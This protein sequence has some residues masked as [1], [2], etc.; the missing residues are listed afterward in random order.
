MLTWGQAIVLALLQGVSELFP[1][2][3]LGHTVLLPAILGWGD[4]QRDPTFVPFVVVLHLGTAAALLWF[5][6][7]EWV[8]VVRAFVRSAYRGRLAQTPEEHLA[9]MLFFGTIPAGVLGALFEQP[10]KAL[11]ATPSVAAVFLIVN[12]L[13]MLISERARRTDMAVNALIAPPLQP[14]R[15]PAPQGTLGIEDL[16]WRHAIA[17]GTAQALALLPGISRSGVTVCAGLLSNMRHAEAARYAFML[18]TPLI[19]AAGLLETPTL[20]GAGPGVL[21]EALV[22]GLLAAGS[23]YL[24]VRYLT[25]YFRVGRLDPFAYYC[26][27]AG[28][29]GLL[30]VVVRGG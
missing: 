19:A 28:L 6:R 21:A 29:A 1:I 10:I 14:A 11:F 20:I 12:G 13:I 4:V 8:G 3:S 25:R 5:Y 30:F 2:S 9:W 23:A 24:S 26:I 27:L 16:T 18:A 15:A 22:G 17:I 7:Q